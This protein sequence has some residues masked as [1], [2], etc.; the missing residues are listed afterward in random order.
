MNRFALVIGLE[1]YAE[2]IPPVQFSEN[3]AKKLHECLMKIRDG[4]KNISNLIYDW[5]GPNPERGLL[6]SKVK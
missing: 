4:H 3:D 6:V 1:K 5:A 2:R